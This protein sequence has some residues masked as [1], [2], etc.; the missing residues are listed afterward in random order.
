MSG[1]ERPEHASG[2]KA[3][4]TAL[5]RV[6]RLLA[7]A[8]AAV[9]G[10]VVLAAVAVGL[11]ATTTFGVRTAYS[12][13][14]DRVPGELSIGTIEGSLVRGLVL[15]DVRFTNATLD[16]ALGLVVVVP[17]TREILDGNIV[18]ERIAVADGYV[19]IA[20]DEDAPPAERPLAAPSLPELPE[21]RCA[22]SRSTP[23]R[24]AP[25]ATTSSSRRRAR[26]S[27]GPPSTS[28]RSPSPWPATA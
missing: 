1:D 10:L 28:R 25:S 16:V 7:I 23:T 19:A 8:G 24:C 6:G 14:G 20:R 18:L 21:T 26:A 22:R 11:L 9:V 27:R 3:P 2:E 15:R 17:A 5:R 12:L 13:L 4:R